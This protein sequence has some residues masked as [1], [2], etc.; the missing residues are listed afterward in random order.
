[1]GKKNNVCSACRQL[2]CCWMGELMLM[3]RLHLYSFLLPPVDLRLPLL[4]YSSSSSRHPSSSHSTQMHSAAFFAA[5]HFSVC[6]NFA[7]TSW[8]LPRRDLAV[9]KARLT[10]VTQ[11]NRVSSAVVSSRCPVCTTSLLYFSLPDLNL[12]L[13]RLLFCHELV[14]LTCSQLLTLLT[15]Q[16][17]LGQS[18]IERFL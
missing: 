15:T 3:W 4:L 8:L 5:R 11:T 1:M 2:Y 14:D 17:L 6:F 10:K 13:L 7:C 9:D 12:V 16:L 18:L